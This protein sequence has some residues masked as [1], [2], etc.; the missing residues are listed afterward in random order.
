MIIYPKMV[1][2]NHVNQRWL[3]FCSQV[4]VM[5]EAIP[6]QSVNIMMDIIN[7]AI[8]MV[9]VMYLLVCIYIYLNFC[10]VFVNDVIKFCL[11]ATCFFILIKTWQGLGS[12]SP[13]N[14]Y[15]KYDINVMAL[16]IIV[17]NYD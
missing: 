6:E 10:L 15:L 12:C 13:L 1:S 16:R 4:F 7:K 9:T 17:K 5:Y 11:Y 3:S 14:F 8:H 2:M